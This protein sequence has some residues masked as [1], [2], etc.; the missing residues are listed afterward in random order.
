MCEEKKGFTYDDLEFHMYK[1]PVSEYAV[2]NND[3]VST[4]PV[5]KKRKIKRSKAENEQLLSNEIFPTP[6]E[7]DNG[8][9]MSTLIIGKVYRIISAEKK[10]TIYH[11]EKRTVAQLTLKSDPSIGPVETRVIRATATV[12]T[13][14]FKEFNYAQDSK[15]NKFYI[16]YEGQRTSVSKNKYFDFAISTVPY[17]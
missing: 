17:S 13:S 2:P 10:N 12:T 1:P 7:M 5:N 14:L 6:A 8:K 9:S 11:G 3:D 15:T 16:V 4:T